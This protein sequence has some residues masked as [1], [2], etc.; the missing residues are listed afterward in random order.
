MARWVA[1]PVPELDGYCI[2]WAQEGFFVLSRRNELLATDSLAS[3][4]KS[5]GSVDGPVWRSMASRSRVAQ[6]LLRFMYYNVIPFGDG[7]FFV[8]FDKS[9]G[10]IKDGCFRALRGLDRPFRVLR[11]AC[12]I[13]PD[14]SVYFGEYLDNPERGPMRIYRLAAGASQAELAYTFEQGSIRHIHGIYFDPHDPALWCVSGDFRHECRILRS[15]DGFRTVETVGEGDETWRSVSLQFT[16][17]G[18][19]YAMDA[20]FEPNAIFRIDRRT[21]QRSRLREVNGPVYYSHAKADD[22]FFSVTAELCPSQRD[23]CATLWHLTDNGCD[24]I[25]S[26]EKDYLHV[27]YFMPGTL[28]F[29]GGPGLPDRFWFSGVGLRKADNQTFCVRRVS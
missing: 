18:I 24:Q 1:E 13:A 15:T 6:R 28:H 12:A 16:A 5:I 11:S 8:T 22:L 4:F 25:V 26:F 3:R 17:E 21:G 7:S 2:E 9:V 23:R 14:G 10:I 27:D 20:E 19:Y 29:S